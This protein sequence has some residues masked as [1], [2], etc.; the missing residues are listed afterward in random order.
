MSKQKC[1]TVMCEYC[2][3]HVSSRFEGE[4]CWCTRGSVGIPRGARRKEKE[5][6]REYQRGR[7]DRHPTEGNLLAV[8]LAMLG[9]FYED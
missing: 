9:D 2:G 8:G 4:V 3:L 5:E 6:I 7:Y 1:D